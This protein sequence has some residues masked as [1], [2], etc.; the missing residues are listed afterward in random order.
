MS[1]TSSCTAQ[2]IPTPDLELST[3]VDVI[4]KVCITP[5]NIRPG[6]FP[7]H[8]FFFGGCAEELYG[9]FA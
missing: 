6:G 4:V 8:V 9:P 1:M 3:D 2:E 5:Y 7:E